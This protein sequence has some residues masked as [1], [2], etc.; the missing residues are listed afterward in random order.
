MKTELVTLL[1]E[2]FPVSIPVLISMETGYVGEDSTDT[3]FVDLDDIDLT[4]KELSP[5]TPCMAF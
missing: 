5:K 4:L 3:I 1:T 2:L